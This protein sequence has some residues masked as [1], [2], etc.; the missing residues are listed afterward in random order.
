[1]AAAGGDDAALE[2][3]ARVVSLAIMPKTIAISLSGSVSA[4]PR[5][6]DERTFRPGGKRELARLD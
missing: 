1:M 3:E 4:S 5:D 2:I 6:P